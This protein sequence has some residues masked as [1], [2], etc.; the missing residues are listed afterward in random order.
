MFTRITAL[1]ISFVALISSLSG[2]DLK[3]KTVSYTDLAYGSH[4]RQVLD[5]TLP[6]GKGDVGLLLMIHGGYW[7]SGDKESF[8]DYL[9]EGSSRFGIACAS[10]NYRY[11]GDASMP[12]MLDDITSA[13][14]KIAS[15][16]K[17]KGYT[18]SKV[19]LSGFSAGA[20]L[21]LLYS[22][23][24][25]KEAP[26]KVVAA[27][28]FSGPADFTDD[29]FIKSSKYLEYI[30]LTDL[31]TIAAGYEVSEA[32]L[33]KVGKALSPAFQVK[34]S[35]VP[36]IIVHGEKDKTV[37]VSNAKTLASKL[38]KANVPYA[39][40]ILPNSGHSLSSKKDSEKA[41]Q[42]DRATRLFIANYL[43]RSS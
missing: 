34:S 38:K 4:E 29:S 37:P 32:D 21:A 40:Y 18:V 24:R 15:T 36:T 2:M 1:I 16:A 30:S 22:Y 10:M 19:M 20:H 13:L 23:T 43:T 6:K 25:S 17:K 12:E 5:L 33:P 3:R 8:R 31:A 35:S 27:A 26:M 42:A 7:V 28:S 41:D 11:L 9:G 39:L 14:K